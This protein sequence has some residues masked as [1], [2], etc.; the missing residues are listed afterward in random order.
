MRVLI[1]FYRKS[2]PVLLSLAAA[3]VISACKYEKPAAVEKDGIVG[4]HL[5]YCSNCAPQSGRCRNFYL[6]GFIPGTDECPV[7]CINKDQACGVVLAQVPP[8]TVIQGSVTVRG[9]ALDSKD[10]PFA[11]ALVKLH[12]PGGK[13]LETRTAGDG[14]YEIVI[15][16]NSNVTGSS[17]FA[18]DLGAAYVIPEE[19]DA[20]PPGFAIIFVA[21]KP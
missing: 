1:A 9:I 17:G 8:G 4:A 2:A 14:R 20:G 7:P 10:S 13:V 18:V 3:L 6:E 12:M 19:G 11:N 15:P 5:S 21:D 16:A